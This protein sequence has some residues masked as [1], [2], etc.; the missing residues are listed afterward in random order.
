MANLSPK[1]VVTA[2]LAVAAKY[3]E[4]KSEIETAE[5]PLLAGLEEEMMTISTAQAELKSYYVELAQGADNLPSYD[6]LISG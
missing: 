5:D 4:L 1:T 6:E 3:K 2:I